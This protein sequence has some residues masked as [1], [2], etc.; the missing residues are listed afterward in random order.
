MES[1]ETITEIYLIDDADVLQGVVPLARL[2]LAL[3]GTR[4]RSN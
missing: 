3:P 2:V 4:R 1:P